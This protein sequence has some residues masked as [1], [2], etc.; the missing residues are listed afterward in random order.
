ML[1][2]CGVLWLYLREG[3]GGCAAAQTRHRRDL[4]EQSEARSS[5]TPLG[6]TPKYLKYGYHIK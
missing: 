1:L 3:Y 2:F 6:G 5:P 4:P